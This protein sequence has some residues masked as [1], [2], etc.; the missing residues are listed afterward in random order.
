MTDPIGE[1]AAHSAGVQTFSP[2]EEDARLEVSLLPP[3]YDS[4]G[5]PYVRMSI[6]SDQVTGQF[7][8]EP[9]DA[10]AL[11]DTLTNAARESEGCERIDEEGR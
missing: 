8:L 1:V 11:A 4:D 7:L 6:R 3:D 5:P 2:P 9:E 10:L